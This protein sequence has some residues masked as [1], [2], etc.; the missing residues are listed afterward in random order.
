MFSLRKRCLAAPCALMRVRYPNTPITFL[1]THTKDG[2]R[3]AHGSGFMPGNSH[4]NEIASTIYVVSQDHPIFLPVHNHPTVLQRRELFCLIYNIATHTIPRFEGLLSAMQLF[5]GFILV[6]LRAGCRH[7]TDDTALRKS[8]GTRM[9]H[10]RAVRL[11]NIR[12]M[13]NTLGQRIAGVL[14]LG[15]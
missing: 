8:F 6:V 5:V 1:C 7:T 4:P 9:R 12:I 10:S 13:S 3:C 2:R 14:A 15:V 11:L